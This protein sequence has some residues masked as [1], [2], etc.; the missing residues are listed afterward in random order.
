MRYYKDCKKK[1]QQGA[2][3]DWCEGRRH[4]ILIAGTA[5][6]ADLKEKIKAGMGVDPEHCT[7][8][9]ERTALCDEMTLAEQGVQDRD[10]LELI[11]SSELVSALAAIDKINLSVIH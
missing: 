7:L 4:E 5:S 9:F 11:V 3:R 2:C 6:V 8:E 10:R 1:L